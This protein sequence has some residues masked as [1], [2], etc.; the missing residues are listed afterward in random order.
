MSIM[1]LIVSSVNA[2]PP[3]PHL[4]P[5]KAEFAIATRQLI[6]NVDQYN[7]IHLFRLNCAMD[8]C[9]LSLTHLECE[10]VGT[11]TQGFTPKTTSWPTWSGFLEISA[12]SKGFL[13]LTIFQASHHQLPAKASFTYL[14]GSHN[15]DTAT[16]LTGFKIEGLIDTKQF[17]FDEK[18]VE[19]IPITGPSH[20]ETLGCGVII[21]EFEQAKQ[22]PSSQ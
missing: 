6:D 16:K 2:A 15:Y 12:R 9:E 13:E 3:T 18:I 5:P 19:Y 7:G 21:P 11:D 14:E 4:K 8:F 22:Q 1:I 10:P 20:T 17:P